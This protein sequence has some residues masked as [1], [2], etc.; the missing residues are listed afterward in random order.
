M[1]YNEYVDS[2][3]AKYGNVPKDYFYVNRNGH[4]TKSQGNT[5][6]NEGLYIHQYMSAT[7]STYLM[8]ICITTVER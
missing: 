1:S 5:R 6:G 2:L 8:Y 4:L 7:I 3:K